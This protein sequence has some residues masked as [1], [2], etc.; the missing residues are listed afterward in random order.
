MEHAA[1]EME[2]RPLCAAL[3]FIECTLLSSSNPETISG[4]SE[5][6]TSTGDVPFPDESRWCSPKSSTDD[7]TVL[8]RSPRVANKTARAAA[9]APDQRIDRKVRRRLNAAF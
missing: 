4:W 7:W 9:L 8:R 5:R 1:I 6:A 3:L 2:D